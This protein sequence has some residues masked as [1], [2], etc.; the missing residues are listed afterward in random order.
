MLRLIFSDTWKPNNNNDY[1]AICAFDSSALLVFIIML[2]WGKCSY[3]ILTV[4]I[5]VFN[6]IA[7]IFMF[8]ILLCLIPI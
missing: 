1:L 6:Y 7:S 4:V 2:R 5:L 8:R 3:I